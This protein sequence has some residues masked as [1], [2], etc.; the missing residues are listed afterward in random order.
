MKITPT[1]ILL[2]TLLMGCKQPSQE[3]PVTADAQKINSYLQAV[4]DKQQIP[5]LTL[6]AT[7]NDTVIYTGAFG[8]KNVETKEPMKQ[9]YNFHWASVS[10]TFVATAIMQLVE[11]GKIKLDEKLITYLP[12]FKL[13]DER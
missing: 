8:F 1:L 10:K 9:G 11:K 4:V 2:I 7:R 5:G 12:Y 13:K 3:K 6:A